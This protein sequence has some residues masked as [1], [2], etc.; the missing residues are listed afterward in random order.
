S[1]D[2]T[3]L[4]VAHTAS[5]FI[6]IYKNFD[7]GTVNIYYNNSLKRFTFIISGSIEISSNE[8]INEDLNKWIHFK[9]TWDINR[10]EAKLFINGIEQTDVI[11]GNITN[12]NFEKGIL[13]IG[14]DSISDNNKFDGYI[15]DLCIKNSVDESNEHFNKTRPYYADN[16][17]LTKMGDFKLDK[18]G[19][20]TVRK[21]TTK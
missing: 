3:Y 20:L 6:T 2:G 16:R 5:P 7:N 4:A 19:N 12:K 11:I 10:N 17:I 21:I 14:C 8:F 1:T 9:I 15:T 13:S 18:F